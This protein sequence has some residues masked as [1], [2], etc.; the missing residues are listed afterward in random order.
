MISIRLIQRASILA[1]MTF[2]SIPFYNTPAH[3]EPDFCIIASNGKTVC[4]KTKGI[5]RMCVTT[6]GSNTICGKFKSIREESA[7]GQE[8]TRNPAPITG[9]QKE[10][11]NFMLTLESC[12]R[13]DE[14]VR[15]QMK[16]FNKGKTREV[17]LSSGNSSI[18]DST[19]RAYTGYQTD[20]GRGAGSWYATVDSKTD[21]IVSLTFNKIPAQ[22]VKAQLFNLPFGGEMK[23]IQFRNVPISN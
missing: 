21:I 15:C 22:V 6:D 7:Q 18:V 1:G 16:I 19:G 13:V 3:A 4:G 23:P 10:V 12:K 14:D 9:Y 20:F 2:A 5:E 17:S 11:N 8:E